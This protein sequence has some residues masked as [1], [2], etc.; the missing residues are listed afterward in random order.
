M[1][2]YPVLAA[3]VVRQSASAGIRPI[4]FNP[5]PGTSADFLSLLLSDTEDLPSKQ[6]EDPRFRSVIKD[7]ENDLRAEIVIEERTNGIDAVVA[8]TPEG[9]FPL[10]RVS[11]MLSE[12]APVILVLKGSLCRS[13]HITIDEPEAHLHP[14][15]QRRGASF[16]ADVVGRGTGVVVTTHSDFFVGEINNLIRSGKLVDSQAPRQRDGRSEKPSVCALQ[17]SRDERWCVGRRITLD[18]V[19]GIDESTFTNVMESL[20]DDS[21]QFI[22]ELL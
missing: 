21:V 18:P 19:D 4:E 16:L 8:V 10:S 12:L 17:F 7:F 2:S 1:Q 6:R 15:M 11:S 20:Y 3:A 22:N 9:E 14:A 13:D 5:L